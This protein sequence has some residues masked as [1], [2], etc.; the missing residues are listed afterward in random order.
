MGE[1]AAELLLS[2]SLAMAL[3]V[4][5]VAVVLLLV[6]VLLAV[7]EPVTT[8]RTAPARPHAALPA[9]ARRALRQTP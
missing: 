5:A 1:R 2:L 9:L 3:A 8:A 7:T 6:T 4:A